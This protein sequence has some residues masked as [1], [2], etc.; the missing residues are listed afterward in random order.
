MAQTTV[1]LLAGHINQPLII[2]DVQVLG[3]GPNNLVAEIY[4]PN[5]RTAVFLNIL[6]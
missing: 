2:S 6:L 3:S 5:L 1:N 4:N